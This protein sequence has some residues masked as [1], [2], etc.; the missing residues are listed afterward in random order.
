[1]PTGMWKFHD[2]YLTKGE[3]L[4]SITLQ[5]SLLGKLIDQ[6]LYT[7]NSGGHTC[8]Q[9]KN[10]DNKESKQITTIIDKKSFSS[11]TSEASIDLRD[12]TLN[13]VTSFDCPGPISVANTN[14]YRAFEVRGMII[15]IAYHTTG[16]IIKLN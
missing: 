16:I 9:K 11:R 13:H 2:F 3:H 5:S 4:E 1:M 14:P 15:S 7:T 6:L 12:Q 10:K 8:I